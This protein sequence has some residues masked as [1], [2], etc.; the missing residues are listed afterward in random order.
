MAICLL[1]KFPLFLSGVDDTYIFST[2]FRNVLKYQ[3]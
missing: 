2:G 1:A 3:I